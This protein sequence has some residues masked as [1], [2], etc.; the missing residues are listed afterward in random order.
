MLVR[1]F[2]FIAI[3]CSASIMQASILRD[4]KALGGND[5]LFKKAK[6]L[7]PEKKITIVQSR[8]T[9]RTLRHEF[10]FEAS[11]VL[12]GDALLNTGRFGLNYQ[13]HIMPYL[14]V[15]LKG[16]ISFNSLSSEGDAFVQRALTVYNSFDQL[17][18]LIPDI[19]YEKYGSYLVVN[20]YPIYGKF[21]LYDLGIGHYDM[22]L[23]AGGGGVWLRRSTAMSVLFG[24]GVGFWL[25]NKFSLRLETKYET[26]KASRLNTTSTQRLHITTVS[27]SI[28]YIL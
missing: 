19:D 14:S 17:E 9:D 4:L 25:A 8:I 21:N 22:Y 6:I 3:F 18:P 12:G 15:S 11:H 1:L 16:H 23:L 24:G 26:Y 7:T 10:N 28:G 27:L 13:F 2:F 5:V 20:W